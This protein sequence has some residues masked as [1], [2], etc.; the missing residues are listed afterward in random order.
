MPSMWTS[1][2]RQPMAARRVE[3]RNSWAEANVSTRYPADPTSRRSAP[4][5]ERS[6][7]TIEIT[8]RSRGNHSPGTGESDE[9]GERAGL[10]LLHD[11]GAVHLYGLLADAQL[12]PDLLVQHPGHHEG[13]DLGFP[14]G[15]GR[16]AV[17]D[18]RHPAV[19]GMLVG[20]PA[21]R[22]PDGGQEGF[23]VQGL[24]QEVDRSTLHRGDAR[25]DVAVAGD[26]DD[27]Q[28]PLRGAK[29]LQYI[30]PRSVANYQ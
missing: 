22:L 19:L 23:L 27:R 18:R 9:L 21:H 30:D 28:P 12:G 29:R 17:P 25:P 1:R 16:D 5:T 8:S 13:E 6:S 11:A 20:R 4:R 2:T 14:W 7:S 10:H 26:E 15:E 24:R 3:P